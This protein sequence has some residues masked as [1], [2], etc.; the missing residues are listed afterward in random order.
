MSIIFQ[1]F[2]NLS[3]YSQ[4]ATIFATLSLEKPSKLLCQSHAKCAKIPKLIPL[5]NGH[6][7]FL[8]QLVLSPYSPSSGKCL[9]VSKS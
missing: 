1:T 2:G 9:S 5:L 8:S 6:T 4:N 3:S 7:R